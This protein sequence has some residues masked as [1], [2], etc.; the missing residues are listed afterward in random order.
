VVEIKFLKRSVAAVYGFKAMGKHIG[1]KKGKKD[2]AIIY[3]KNQCNAAAV[4]SL[5]KVKTPVKIVN[6]KHLKDGKAQAIVINAGVANVATG[7]QG[8]K[9]AENMAELT[10]K[11]LGIKTEDV[12]VSST[13]YIGKMMPMDMIE[14]GI[15]GS[16]KLL[17]KKHNAADAIM[18]TDTVKK[19]IAVKHDDGFKIGAIAKGSGMIHPNMA[20][21][22]CFLTTDADLSS[23]ELQEALGKAVNSSFNMISVDRDTSTSDMVAIMAN[24][25]V[26][27]DIKE[28][29][30]ALNLV[31]KR[32][33]K[34]IAADGEG[35]T[36]L[37]ISKVVGAKTKE[38]AKKAAK[39]VVSSNL[40]KCAMFGN[41]PNW[42][43]IMAAVANED[44]TID[45]A[46]MDIV[47][48]GNVVLRDGAPEKFDEKVVSELLNAEEVEV[49]VNLNMGDKKATAYGCDMTYEYV[50]I[51]AEYHT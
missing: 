6:T 38:D 43:R 9:D 51:N 50:K 30:K 23:A 19:E 8:I 44:I 1:L 39:A 31:C 46:K 17:H 32:M 13:G 2:L 12:L 26:N 15:K 16:K 24:P 25:K 11:E 49:V 28:F 48:Q 33:A 4:H 40:V 41:D 22:L 29:K 18:T 7:E 47:L 10:A 37:V 34:R 5:N 3:C 42:G 21:M 20:T 36:K 45:A 27:V 14:K 35:A